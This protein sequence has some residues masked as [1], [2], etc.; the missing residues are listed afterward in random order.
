M[1]VNYI[2]Q[3]N[4][5]HGVPNADAYNIT[6]YLMAGFLLIGFFCNIFIR[7]V[8]ERHYMERDDYGAMAPAE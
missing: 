5:E 2:R 6:M 8:H 3:Y 1:L 7:P 4:V